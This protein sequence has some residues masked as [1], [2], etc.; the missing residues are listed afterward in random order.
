MSDED[1]RLSNPDTQMARAYRKVPAR[2]RL[3]LSG[4]IIQNH[5]EELYSPHARAFPDRFRSKWRDWNDRFLDYVENGYGRV[6][7]GPQEGRIEEM[8]QVMG[9]GWSTAA[10]RTSWTCRPRRSTTCAST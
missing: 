8:R 5:L 9:R 1:H 2:R 10:R 4:S 7:V 3:M 6:C